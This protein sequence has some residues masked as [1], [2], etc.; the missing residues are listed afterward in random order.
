MEENKASEAEELDEVGDETPPDTTSTPTPKPDAATLSDDQKPVKKDNGARKKIIVALALLLVAL[1]AGYFLF[2]GDSSVDPV[3]NENDQAPSVTDDQQ[4]SPSQIVAPT[5]FDQIVYAHGTTDNS[6]RN[7]FT[8][9]AAGGDRQDLGFTFGSNSVLFVDRDGDAYIVGL[10]NGE[11]HYG[12]AK[13]E[14]VKVFSSTDQIL[15]ALL[16]A[17]SSSIVVST[18]TEIGQSPVVKTIHRVSTDGTQT[19]TFF[20]E[21]NEDYAGIFPASW[22]GDTNVLLARRSCYQC[23]GYNANLISFDES[24]TETAVYDAGG[25]TSNTTGYIFNEDGS[26]ALFFSGSSYTDAEIALYSLIGGIGDPSGAPFSFYELD[27]ATGTASVIA[28]VGDISDAKNGGYTWPVA[29]WAKSGSKQLPAYAYLTKAFVQANDNSYSNYFESGLGNISSLHA[30]DDDEILVGSRN[31]DG[32][33]IQYFNI[34]TQKGAIVMETLFTTSIL[35][36]TLK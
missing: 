20:S 27:T 2:M 29:A 7:L 36:V 13:S 24:G 32:E 14:P 15:G 34:K 33:T 10:S 23:D 18:L 6:P 8:R 17:G 19:S 30:I 28:T 35:G 11:V 12:K 22:N 3:S 1:G 9:P 31:D 4:T 5:Q 16:D 25:F 21:S 26:K